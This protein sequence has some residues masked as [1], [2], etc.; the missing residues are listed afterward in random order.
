MSRFSAHD[1]IHSKPKKTDEFGKF[2]ES[3]ELFSQTKNISIN[4]ISDFLNHFSPAIPFWGICWR[5]LPLIIGKIPVGTDMDESIGIMVDNRW[6][7]YGRYM[8]KSEEIEF[9]NI[10]N[11]GYK[12]YTES[13]NIRETLKELFKLHN[14]FYN[15]ILKSLKR[16][17]TENDVY[18]NYFRNT[19]QQYGKKLTEEFDCCYDDEYESILFFEEIRTDVQS[20]KRLGKDLTKNIFKYLFYSFD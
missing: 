7:N 13:K 18:H 3:L 9:I 15:K 10:I 17:I 12:I 5:D 6:Y 16:E 19:G 14:L 4:N 20:Q 2:Y 11:N 1:L 8:N